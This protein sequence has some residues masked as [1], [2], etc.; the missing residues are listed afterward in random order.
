MKKLTLTDAFAN[1]GAKLKN[2]RW[3]CSAIADDGALVISCWQHFLKSYDNGHKRYHD[4]LSRWLGN[5][6]GRNLLAKHLK[7]AIEDNLQV[8]LVVATLDDTKESISTDG[9]ASLLSKT[10]SIEKNLVGKVVEFDGDSFVI[11]FWP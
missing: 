5:H 10:F 1:Y 6:Q 7:M 8:R 11:E 4:H 9:D 3:A 2:T